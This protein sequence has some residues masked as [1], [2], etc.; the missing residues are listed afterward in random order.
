MNMWLMK[1]CVSDVDFAP[2]PVHAEF[3]IWWKTNPLIESW[4][5]RTQMNSFGILNRRTGL[6]N[7]GSVIKLPSEKESTAYGRF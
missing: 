3:G 6:S 1:T 2:A 7:V 4:Q 5:K